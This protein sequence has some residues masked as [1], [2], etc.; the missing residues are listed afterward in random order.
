[1]Q[2]VRNGNS[3]IH[4]YAESRAENMR[5]EQW[6]RRWQKERGMCGDSIL[7]MDNFF[8]SF[9]SFSSIQFLS[10]PLIFRSLS[11]FR[12]VSE[13]MYICILVNRFLQSHK[14]FA[15]KCIHLKR[16]WQKVNRTHT[17]YVH[18]YTTVEE[19]IKCKTNSI[20]RLRTCTS[21]HKPFT[22][23]HTYSIFFP[24]FVYTLCY[25]DCYEWFSWYVC[26]CMCVCAYLYAR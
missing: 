6:Q 26:V 23:I 20:S 1:M 18:P 5:S 21:C 19:M 10:T 17:K 4:W 13:W 11:L 12:C 16:V 24:S 2:S 7:Q 22:F 3:N 8:F 9:S 25:F 15:C 14:R